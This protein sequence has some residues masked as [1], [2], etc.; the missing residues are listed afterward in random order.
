MPANNNQ[1]LRVCY[2]GTYRENYSRNQMMIAGLRMNGVVVNEC[3][4]TLWHGIEDRVRIASGEW[5]KPGFWKRVISAYWHL[6]RK[7]LKT[8][9]HDILIVGYP[10]QFDVLLARIL[11]WMKHKPLVWDVFM[12]IY[13]ITIERGL[14]KQ[15]KL[16][17]K[18]LRAIEWLALRLPDRLILDT[19]DYVQWFV[20]TY[21]VKPERFY[22]VP[23]GA[24]DRTFSPVSE[25]PDKDD[26]F[27]VLYYGTFIPNHG[28][29]YMIEAAQ[30]LK[31]EPCIQFEF[32]GTGPELQ[33]A[34]EFSDRNQ[35]SNVKFI[36]WLEKEQLKHHMSQVDICLGAF[37]ITPQ[38]MMTIQNKIY[39]SVAMR[40]PLIS[41]DS[42][43]IRQV[44][45][46]G[47]NIYLCERANG[48][49]IADAITALWKKPTLREHIAQAG[50]MLYQEKYSLLVN[51][52]RYK[53]CLHELSQ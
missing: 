20:K 4:E 40:K 53:T 46:H 10:G 14:D 15:N 5:L 23:T 48:L 13:L 28:V 2:F 9:T 36:K 47:E 3:H 6:L 33:A 52:Q 1:P 37:G 19:N 17:A 29:I 35:L 30:I 39:E 49:A 16:S 21:Q 38:S 34:V 45:T 22:L 8:D 27:T 42:P 41:G 44:F 7:Y 31:S 26:K 32:I 18:M 51:G 11:S 24:D 43:A 25:S 50:Y 12:S